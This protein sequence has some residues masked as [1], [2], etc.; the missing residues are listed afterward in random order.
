MLCPD[1]RAPAENKGNASLA[2]T[3]KVDAWACGVLAYE[4]LVGCPPFGMST[5]EGS[6]KAILYQKPKVPQWLAP[7]AA[8]FINWALTKKASR[9][10]SVGHLLQHAWIVAH[11]YASSATRVVFRCCQVF[12]C[13][14]RCGGVAARKASHLPLLVRTVLAR[15]QAA[16]ARARAERHAAARSEPLRARRQR[17]GADVAAA[18]R[19]WR[20]RGRMQPAQPGQQRGHSHGNVRRHERVCTERAQLERHA[21]AESAVRRRA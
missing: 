1:K 4:L 21:L 14:L 19:T 11:V 13:V 3:A 2:Y 10:P 18:G 6:V 17:R 12:L 9:R 15:L 16:R 8:D 20:R 7:A 5:R